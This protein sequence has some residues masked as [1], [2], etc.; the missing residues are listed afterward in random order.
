MS[1]AFE[2]QHGLN[3]IPPEVLE[4]F[5]EKCELPKLTVKCL[6]LQL[7]LPET[8]IVTINK[9]A[10]TDLETTIELDDLVHVLPAIEGG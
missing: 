2:L 7:Q 9:T 10:V 5:M 4:G 6:R 8:W 1:T 3:V